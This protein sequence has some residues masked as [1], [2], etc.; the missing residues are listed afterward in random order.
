MA[1]NFLP[2]KSPRDLWR[3]TGALLGLCIG[4]TLILGT[5]VFF[6]T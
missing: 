4:F 1:N 2:P 3:E 6:T 5:V